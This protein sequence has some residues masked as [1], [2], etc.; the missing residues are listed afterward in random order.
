VL[1]VLY[2]QPTD[3]FYVRWFHSFER[4]TAVLGRPVSRSAGRRTTA[5]TT[6]VPSSWLWKPVRSWT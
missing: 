4:T 2:H 1:M 3:H 6:G 5:G